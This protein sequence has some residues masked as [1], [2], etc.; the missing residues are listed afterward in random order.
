MNSKFTLKKR[1]EITSRI[2]FR[3]EVVKLNAKEWCRGFVTAGTDV[4]SGILSLFMLFIVWPAVLFWRNT[5][6]FLITSIRLTDVEL[7]KL[8]KI[9]QNK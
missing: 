6:G 3:K 4:V 9:I 7:E 8:E 1:F 2:Q 5:F